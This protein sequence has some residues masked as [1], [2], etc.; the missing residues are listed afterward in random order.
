MYIMN[1]YAK[2]SI[3]NRYSSPPMIFCAQPA[4]MTV[5]IEGGEES[6]TRVRHR[7][8]VV[9]WPGFAPVPHML[10]QHQSELGLTS[11]ELNV[12]LHIFMHWH[13]AGELP[14]PHTATI[15]KRMGSS[16][17]AVQQ[18]VNSLAN[19][20]MI[21][22]VRNRRTEPMRY[23]VR[24]LLSKLVPRA[25]EWLRLRGI[26]PASQETRSLKEALTE[27]F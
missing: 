19:K 24:P 26:A 18:A 8:G 23:D 22:K 12:F 15:A 21:E 7:L 9:G 13:D 14:F 6:G 3:H 11:K 25:K 17:R 10:L 16:Q 1:N 4:L 2:I 20:G 5:S 27:P